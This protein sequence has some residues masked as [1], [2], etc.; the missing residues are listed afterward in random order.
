[1]ID[2][3]TAH[4]LASPGALSNIGSSPSGSTRSTSSAMRCWIS[5]RGGALSEGGGLWPGAPFAVQGFANGSRSRSCCLPRCNSTLGG[6]F[7]SP[8]LCNPPTPAYPH[9]LP[10][11]SPHDR[12]PVVAPQSSAWTHVEIR[13][14]HR[15][16][17][18]AVQEPRLRVSAE[19][20]EHPRQRARCGVPTCV[21]RSFA[22]SDCRRGGEAQGVRRGM[23]R[24]GEMQWGTP[25]G[26]TQHGM[27][28]HPIAPYVYHATPRR[29]APRHAAPPRSAAQRSAA[30]CSAVQCRPEREVQ[31]QINA[32]T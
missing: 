3:L 6:C 5:G 11:R 29:A 13:R 10:L 24:C 18:F 14:A 19:E 31:D 20:V 8:C 25:Q 15:I 7:W 28:I 32:M 9:E 21:R 30:Q 2:G 27:L 4:P 17:P 16:A 22:R 12:G 26:L 1:M 23:A